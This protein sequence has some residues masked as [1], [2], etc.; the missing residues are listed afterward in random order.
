MRKYIFTF[1]LLGSIIVPIHGQTLSL[2]SCRALALRNNKSLGA[3]RLRQNMATY[4]AK[5]AKTK[6]LPKID[7]LGGYEYTSKEISLLNN[8]QKNALS[9]FGTNIGSQMGGDISSV[10]G[11]LVQQGVFTQDQATQ[12]GSVLNKAGASFGTALNQVGQKIVDAFRTDT[13]NIFAGSITLRQPIYMGGSIIAANKIANIGEEMAS[14]STDATTQTILYNIDQTYWTVVSLN[15][16]QKL[17]NQFLELVKKLS[18]DVHKMINQGVATKA[19]GLRVDVKV[20]EA[21]MTVTQAENGLSLAKMLLCQQCGLPLD[22]NVTLLDENT[23]NIVS[24]E[25]TPSADVNIAIDNRPEL[26]LLQNLV[27]V[28]RQSTKIVRAAYLPQ[29][30]L[31]GG[32][33]FSNPNVYNGYQ[34]KFSGVW[35]VGVVVRIPLWNWFEG[36][37]K[38]KASKVT[39]SI[40]NLELT[41][42]QEKMQLQVQQNSF[43]IKEA[44]K[45]LAMSQK[46]VEN[47]NE[48]LRCA[49]LGFKEGVLQTTEV[50]EAQTAWLTAQTQKIDAEIDLNMSQIG[51]RKAMGILREQ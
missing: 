50:M 32:Y 24:Q 8:T 39:T 18:D 38:V 19:D 5:A 51:L 6:Y 34:N 21:E 10:L 44:K 15:H 35:N 46:N 41:D 17:A 45:R 23:S 11:N 28:S 36:E 3:A 14:N 22:A 1:V 26:K 20:N 12:I 13:R 30:A 16:K 48:N 43:K 7:V 31:T 4:T 27:D 47:A 49:N 29:V 40:A 2:D 33:M 37:Y 42:A 9:N 25:E